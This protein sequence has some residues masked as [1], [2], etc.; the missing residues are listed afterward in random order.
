[1]VK[2][3]VVSVN[4]FSIKVITVKIKGLSPLIAHNFDTG[5]IGKIEDK[6][7][8][9]A[10]TEKHKVR[11]PE[12]DFEGAKHKSPL[13]FEGF[14]ASGFKKAMIRGAKMI[15]LVMK[16]VQTSMF[17]KAD[18]EETQLVK[19]DGKCRMRT[20]MVRLS[21]GVAD[22]RYRPE[23]LDWKAVLNIEYN[24]GILS[25]EK[26]IQMVRAAGYGVGVGDW[27][28][29]KGGTYGRFEVDLN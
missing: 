22:V 3:N 6:Q 21:S 23:Y 26:I 10:K 24:A 5:T 25:P 15:G 13:G 11:V 17:V 14:P 4:D 18:C 16:D 8:G 12:N 27:R 29:D 9:K 19:V 2:K 1:M 28:P 20:D 7:Q